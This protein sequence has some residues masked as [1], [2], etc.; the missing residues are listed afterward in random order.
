MAL[1]R[2]VCKEPDSHKP[3]HFC[4]IFVRVEAHLLG[5]CDIIVTKWK[6]V[7][8]KEGEVVEILCGTTSLKGE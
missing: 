3:Q 6:F 7:V 8:L 5:G 4:F 1:L 2:V